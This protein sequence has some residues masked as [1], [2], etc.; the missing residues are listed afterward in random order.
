MNLRG[1]LALVQKSLFSYTSSRGFFWTLAFGWMMPPLVFMF[2]WVAAAGGGHIGGFARN[3]FLTYYIC[4]VIINQLTYPTSHWIVGESITDGSMSKWL[5]WPV[6][7]I[8]HG[9]A[10]DLATKTVCT[11][12]AFAAAGLV[13]VITRVQFALS[14]RLVPLFIL[15]LLLALALRFLLGYTLALLAFWTQ[16]SEAI[17][18]VNDTFVFLLA[19]QMIPATLLPGIMQ[20]M[21]TVM[22]YKYM[23]DFPVQLL[24]GKLQAQQILSGLA[25]QITWLVLLLLLHHLIW[26]RGTQKYTSVG[27]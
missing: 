20:D 4:L 5:L 9:L 14:A 3:D 26:S 24:M 19:G 21:S 11:P 17:L 13:A 27:G 2:V 6:P 23:L 22:P 8:Y 18:A 1:G 12:F 16:H 7:A 15:A 10:G 25:I